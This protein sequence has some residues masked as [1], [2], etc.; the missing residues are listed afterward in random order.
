MPG[1]NS[2]HVPQK[3]NCLIIVP[4]VLSK[5]L[6]IWS[7]N[8]YTHLKA[9]IKT[10]N[11]YLSLSYKGQSALFERRPGIRSEVLDKLVSRVLNPPLYSFRMRFRIVFLKNECAIVDFDSVGQWCKP[12]FTYK[13]NFRQSR[14]QIFVP[15]EYCLYSAKT[16]LTSAL[17]KAISNVSKGI[18]YVHLST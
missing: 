17:L 5:S 6:C 12:G 15:L 7:I 4:T 11:K 3:T 2:R 14:V 16:F 10:L 13:E 9:N 1:S 18:F 8:K